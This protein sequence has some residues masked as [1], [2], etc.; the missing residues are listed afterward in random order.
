M[1]LWLGNSLR[2][3]GNTIRAKKTILFEVIVPD[4]VKIEVV[5]ETPAVTRK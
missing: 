4:S 1:S 2:V 5:P 3:A